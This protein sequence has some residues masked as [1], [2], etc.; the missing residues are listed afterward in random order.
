MKF[1]SVTIFVLFLLFAPEC[2]FAQ[3]T[4]IRGRVTDSETNN[5]IPFANIFFKGTLQGTSTDFDGNY[6]IKTEEAFDSLYVSMLGFKSKAKKVKKGKEQ[7]L[8]FQLSPEAL[9]LTTVIVEPGENPAIPIVE[10]TIDRKAKFNFETINLL[11]FRSYTKQ[12]VDIDN[13]TERM[14]KRK[15]LRPL[16][17]MWD[18]MDSLVGNDAKANLPVAMSEVL[19]DITI[20]KVGNRKR[21]DVNAVKVKFVGMKDGEAGAQLTGT[22]FSNYNFNTN[23]VIISTKEFLSPIADRAL[24][25]YNYH[26]VDTVELDGQ[27]CYKIDVI[28]KNAMDPCFKGSIWIVDSVFALKQLD[29]EITKDVNFN[30]VD[31]ARISQRLIQTDVGKYIPVQSR[32]MVDYANVTKRLVSLMI[33]TYNSLKDVNTNINR[34]STFFNTRLNFAEDAISKDSSY[35]QQARHEP[36]SKLEEK[37]YAMIDT[38]RAIPFIKH[39][40]N[41]LYFLFSGYKDIGP[42]DVGHYMYLYGY[43]AYEGDRLKLNFRTNNK[44]S[45]KWVLRGYGA[46]GFRDNGFKYNLQLERILT[47]NP[48]SKAGVQYRDDIDIIGSNF[49]VSNNINLGQPPA[50]L[51]SL[52]TQLQNISRLVKK[53]EYRAWYERDLSFGISSRF[54][55][56]NIRTTPL[57][58]VAYNG[59]VYSIFQQRSFSITELVADMRMAV[60]ERFIQNGNERI[61]VGGKRSPVIGVV[62][63]VALKNVL[64]GDFYYHKVTTSYDNRFRFGPWGNTRLSVKAGKV[65]SEIPYTL[66][67]VH[68]GNETPFY[69]STVF[70]AM[71]FFEFVSDQYIETFVQH[72][73]NGLFFNRIPLIKKLHL[74]EVL[75]VNAVY[76]SLSKK[77]KLFNAGNTFTELSSKPYAEVSAGIENILD[78]FRVDFIY[79][80][81]YNTTTYKTNYALNNSGSSISNWAIRFGLGFAF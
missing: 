70:N 16:T 52:G 30:L 76:G 2:F 5:G 23:I 22:D 35:W 11:S 31:R 65:F 61:S 72:H 73:F 10:K 20:Y 79:R 78:I 68:R 66:L 41:I 15:I 38:V 39:G 57:F 1:R 77:N 80:L 19:S 55:F 14:R 36:L 8:D 4:I 25:F 51:Y 50:N 7:V 9:V 53:Q 26:L 71:N 6:F 17:T 45:K 56:Q 75:G 46:Y 3:Q 27:V 33:T 21:E 69:A 60:R 67:N 64:D 43:N 12:E 28:P 40:V 62:Y 59:D 42:V 48:W 63:T 49:S 37:S 44:F 54:T 24:L 34:D 29:L 81:S 74:R 32:V 18:E 47:R 13:V 58:P